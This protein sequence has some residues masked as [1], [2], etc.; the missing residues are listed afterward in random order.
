LQQSELNLENVT[1]KVKFAKEQAN[2]LVAT[3]GLPGVSMGAFNPFTRSAS[4]EARVHNLSSKVA[5]ATWD[6]CPP[7][8]SSV[9]AVELKSTAVGLPFSDDHA[10]QRGG[11]WVC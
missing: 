4:L 7:S 9:A 3:Y 8:S 1:W 6:V 10:V 5:V 11:R 2:N